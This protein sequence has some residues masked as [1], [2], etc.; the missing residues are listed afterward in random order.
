MSAIDWTMVS[1]VFGDSLDLP[2][3]ERERFVRERCEGRPA[4]RDAVLRLLVADQDAAPEFPGQLDPADLE[5]AATVLDDTPSRIGPWQLVREIGEGGMGQVFLAERADGQFEQRVAIKLLKRGMDSHAILARF[6][7]ERRI[8]AGL[9]HPNIARLL[10]GGI[11]EDGRPYFVME[12]VDGQA[13]TRYSDERRMPVGDRLALFQQVCVALEY[14]HRNLVVHRD[15]KPSNILVTSD[16]HPKLLDFGIAKLL[17]AT[18]GDHADTLTEAGARPMTPEYAA[19]EQ[20]TGGPISTSTDVYSLGVVLHELLAGSRPRRK[21]ALSTSDSGPSS[22]SAAAAAISSPAAAALSTDAAHLRRTLSGD[23]DT[24]VATALRTEPERRYSSVAALRED[25]RRYQQQ[26]PI[27]A[28]PDTLGYRA[29]RFIRRNRAAVAASAA[30]ALLTGAFV[31]TTLRQARALEAERDRARHEAEAAS[32]VSDF[33]VG[34]FEVA[35]PMMAGAGDSIRARE[36][37][38]R[39]AERMEDDLAGQ[40]ELQARMLSVIGQA[41]DNLSRSDLAEPLLARA[42]ELLRTGTDGSSRP[43]YVASLLQ[44]GRTR[45]RMG[46]YAGAR[47]LFQQALS[48]QRS[49]DPADPLVG[50]LLLELAGSYHMQGKADSAEFLIEQVVTSLNQGSTTFRSSPELLQQLTLVLTYARDWSRLDS[51]HASAVRAAQALPRGPARTSAIAVA[52]SDWAATMR[53]QGELEAADSMFTRALALHRSTGSGSAAEGGV[54][55]ELAA[56]AMQ[57]GKLE[58]ADSLYGDAV[59]IL[60]ARLGPDHQLVGAA[61]SGWAELHRL[62]GRTDEAVGMYRRVLASYQ[63]R[64]SSLSYVPVVQWRLAQSLQQAGQLDQALEMFRQSI[65]GHVQRF[66]AD[67]ILTANVRRDYAGALMEAGRYGDAVVPLE[68]AMPVLA[69]RWGEN[70]ARVDTVRGMLVSARASSR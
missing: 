23:L 29:S 1:E 63:K 52:Y 59:R 25:I 3:D 12:H 8:L 62:T 45:S 16:G 36:L 66:P 27:L 54:L 48:E 34:I 35:D 67:Y 40:P 56:L 41:Y 13:I 55:T 10:D 11:A 46:D 30:L 21:D 24:I 5:A 39:G 20:F 43:G 4:E 19:P 38:D 70:D 18:D 65:A 31:V 9:E 26:L 51:V 53:R 47:E 32:Q 28:R 37:L 61:L 33:L 15:L 44:L 50:E 60:E 6:L 69:R 64:S 49:L 22:L 2:Q 58:R 14:A 68:R 42:V 57:R 17:T 7:R